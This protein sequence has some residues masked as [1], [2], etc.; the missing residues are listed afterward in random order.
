MGKNVEISHGKMNKLGGS[1]KYPT[2]K[3]WVWGGDLSRPGWRRVGDL[4]D[5]SGSRTARER[6][7]AQ[8]QPGD[9]A[10]VGI[11]CAGDGTVFTTSAPCLSL[12]L[13]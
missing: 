4:W 10:A 3:W 5:S 1:G 7:H 8:L 2:L 13:T 9:A 6:V 11:G 12:E